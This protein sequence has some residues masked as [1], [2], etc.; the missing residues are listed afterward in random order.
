MQ[1]GFGTARTNNALEFSKWCYGAP[2]ILAW[3][4]PGGR[5]TRT[6]WVVETPGSKNLW[7][8]QGNVGVLLLRIHVALVF[9]RAQG[10][11]NVPPSLRRLDHPI[12]VAAFAGHERIREPAA[13]LG[14]LFLA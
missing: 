13:E 11:Y 6:N 7:P 12:E 14:N 9:E 1:A 3:R 5:D 4:R 2:A 10:G 8:L